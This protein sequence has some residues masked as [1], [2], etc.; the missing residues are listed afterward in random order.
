MKKSY[1]FIVALLAASF[2]FAQGSEDFTNLAAGT[3]YSD[4][5]FAGNNGITWT[6]T[7]S[8]DA[9]QNTGGLPAQLPAL[10]LR[11][12]ASNSNV[13]SSTITGGIQDFS[14]KLYKQFTGGGNRQVELFVNGTSYGTSTPFDDY[15]EHIFS[16]TGINVAGAVTIELRNITSKQIAIDD[17]SWTAM[18]GGAV[19][20]TIATVSS[21]DA[22]VLENVGTVD[23]NVTLNQAPVLDKTIDLALTSGNAA[24]IGNFTTQT[25][26]FTAGGSL[27]Q[28][29]TLNITPGQLS[30]ASEVFDFMLTNPS[31]GLE[32]GAD[33]TYQLT[34]NQM[35]VNPSACS[36]L[37]FSEYIEG[38]SSNKAFEI[39]N[40]TNQTIDLSS[41]AVYLYKNGGST[42]YDTLALT[43][44]LAYDSVYVA[45]SPS[46]DS[47][48]IRIKSDTLHSVCFFNGDDALALFNG[49]TMV[50]VIGVIGTDPG[51]SWTV[52]TGATKDYTLV[53][54]A[55][56]TNG[57]L[58][59]IGV[60]DTQWDVYPQN[61]FSFLGAHT[62]TGCQTQSSLH[63][64]VVTDANTIC[65]GDS[66]Q[67]TTTTTGGT[68]PYSYAWSFGDGGSAMNMNENHT[69]TTAGTYTISLVVTDD[70]SASVD[71]TF[72]IV[73]QNCT[74]TALAQT[75]TVDT[76]VCVGS[77]IQ[78]TTTATGGT[79]PYSYAWNFGDGNSSTTANGT[80]SYAAAGSYTVSLTVTDDAS[81]SV[82]TTI[83]VVIEDCSSILENQDSFVTIYPNPSTNG[84]INL[85]NIE[86]NSIVVIYNV[87]GKAVLKTKANN[88]DVINISELVKGNYFI[89]IS[90][91]KNIITKKLIIE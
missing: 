13:I 41:Y 64:V 69:Y 59:W 90:N 68:S 38:S 67:F 52:G 36:E 27:T 62:A 30:S 82:D 55:T 44:M 34:V 8:R 1:L 54:K 23:V 91:N 20:D 63:T 21:V 18:A 25:L 32:I 70:A 31:T 48:G 16:V 89:S 72:N 86:N 9:A 7:Q 2:S 74:A 39:Y 85:T 15:N 26:T 81:A 51:S 45:A 47:V 84:V 78:Y 49:N 40:P 61:D 12:T 88:N 46:A 43:G 14:V 3:S 17:I 65:E 60:G 19:V 56:I 75:T 10:M 50:D 37:F 11:R 87:I 42:P 58:T 29:V 80:H 71:T 53:R 35:P 33:T 79:T 73:V 28:T 4:G 83:S 76:L 57:E 66:I 22:S 6:Y 5:S 77:D 24:V